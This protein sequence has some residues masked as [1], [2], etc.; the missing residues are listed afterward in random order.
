M[1]HYDMKKEY[2]D[3]HNKARLDPDAGGHVELVK[4]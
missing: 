2:R 3:L 4:L 1:R